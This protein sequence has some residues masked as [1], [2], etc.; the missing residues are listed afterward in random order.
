MKKNEKPRAPRYRARVPVEFESG[1]GLTRDFSASGIYFETDRSF[2][3]GQPLE[4]I[5]FLEHVDTTGPVRVK[6]LGEI[7]R[8]EESGKRTGVAATIDY[9]SF[10]TSE[11]ADD[12]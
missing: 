3:P 10:E 5:I 7:V 2:S 6:C 11:W 8:V 9:Y 1:K 12:N 4:F